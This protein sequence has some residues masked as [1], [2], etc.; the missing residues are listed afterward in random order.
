[1]PRVLVSENIRSL[2]ARFEETRKLSETLV[3]SLSDAD[4]T[5]QSM[6]DASPAK[7]H[8][9][10]TTWFWETFLLRDH[11]KSYR[12]FNEKYPYLF[13]SYYN[14]EG[15]RIGRSTR[16]IL[17]RPTLE[18]ILIWR[19]HVN[20]EILCLLDKLED[21]YLVH[22]GIAHEQQHQ[23]LL[24]TD[25]KHAFFHSPLGPRIF[26]NRLKNTIQI[27]P[28]WYEH[29]GG[30]TVVG[31]DGDHFAFD[32]E[33]P[34]HQVLIEPFGLSKKLVTNREW[35][36]F[37]KDGGYQKPNLWLSD[38]WD[39]VCTNSI[40][41]PLYWSDN[42]SFTLGGWQTRDPDHPVTHISYY[43]ADAF[44]TWAGFRLPT[45]FEWEVISKDHVASG[46]NQ[47]DLS[48]SPHPVGSD[49]LF[50]DCWQFTR[51]AYLPYPRYLP[52][53]GA[54][55]EY[56]GK[57]MSG[58]FVLK[59]S[60]CVTVPGHSRSSYRN[61]FYPHQRWQFTGLRLAKDL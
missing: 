57:F 59:G 39:W 45:E 37:I 17:S 16:G 11:V 58:Q 49:T 33:G 21:T 22:L 19:A 13:N 48:C 29:R 10:H 41:A 27:E 2:A 42:Q 15:E 56:N 31:H 3:G 24:L 52:A 60:S 36:Q 54:V 8:L 35:D 47:L 12:L 50:G 7:W 43:E 38:G 4:A 32:N 23:E 1:V 5:I 55:G 53:E 28:G 34:C 44:A 46:G 26:R 61:F 30:L 14:S 9:A 18:E 25:L 40:T 20:E 51:S 6:E